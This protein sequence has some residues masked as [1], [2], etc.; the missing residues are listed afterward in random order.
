MSASRPSGPL[1][2]SL[3]A[4]YFFMHLLSS[5]DFVKN[6]LLKKQLMNTIGF[7]P[8]HAQ[9]SVDPNLVPNCLHN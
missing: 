6:K 8:D 9:H 3:H 1:V 5:A 7:D 2:N 4:G